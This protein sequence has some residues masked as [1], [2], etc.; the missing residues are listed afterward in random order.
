ML[1]MTVFPNIVLL[2]MNLVIQKISDAEYA[3][4]APGGNQLGNFP[5]KM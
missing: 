4:N 5:G 3:S 1:N 2:A